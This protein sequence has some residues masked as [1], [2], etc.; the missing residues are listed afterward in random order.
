M[1][2]VFKLIAKKFAAKKPCKMCRTNEDGSRPTMCFDCEPF[3]EVDVQ[4]HRGEIGVLIS[5]NDET[6][7]G[8]I[9]PVKYCPFCGRKFGKGVN[10]NA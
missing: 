10:K 8:V 3:G 5:R 1:F 6:S 7:F 4:L 2:K 9:V